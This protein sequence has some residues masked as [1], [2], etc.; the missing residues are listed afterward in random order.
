MRVR[1]N[2]YVIT[3]IF[4]P[5]GL[6]FLV[7]TFILLLRFLFQSA[8]MIIR[9]GLPVSMLPRNYNNGIRVMQSPGYVLIVLEM[10]HEVRIIP[11]SGPTDGRPALDK[12]IKEWLGES[13]GH[14]GG[15][16]PFM[17]AVPI[18]GRAVSGFLRR[19]H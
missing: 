12:A 5:M 19:S 1:I 7:Y 8:E 15:Q 2:R 3:E 14:K 4:G 18:Y 9:R 11:T 17:T 16:S 10:A 6:G 13:R